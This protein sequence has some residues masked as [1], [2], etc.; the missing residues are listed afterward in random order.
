MV[1]SRNAYGFSNYSDEITLLC[2]FVPEPVVLAN[3][4]TVTS[5]TV[6]K[7]T[8]IDGYNGGS[9]ILDYTIYFD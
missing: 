1:E 7:V 3:D 4:A 5:D 8:W 9:P 2:A 6:I